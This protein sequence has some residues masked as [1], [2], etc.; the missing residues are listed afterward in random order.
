MGDPSSYYTEKNGKRQVL[1]V[2]CKLNANF[3]RNPYPILCIHELL[4]TLFKSTVVTEW[5]GMKENDKLK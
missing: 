4:E 1:V 2:F 5:Y 3:K